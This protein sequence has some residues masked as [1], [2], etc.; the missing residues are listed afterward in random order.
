MDV[1]IGV[2][3]VP[4]RGV[5]KIIVRHQVK[6]FDR[7]HRAYR[8][9]ADLRARHGVLSDE[10]FQ[11]LDNPCD[12]TVTHELRDRHQAEALLGSTEIRAAAAEAGVVGES[13]I[14]LTRSIA[15]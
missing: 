14:W 1:G 7:W 8:G 15:K 10:V 11:A 13:T 5:V 12:V 9:F 6:D 2:P 3:E 4:D